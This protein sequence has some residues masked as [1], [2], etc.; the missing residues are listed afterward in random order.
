[1]FETDEELAE[2]WDTHTSADYVEDW[3]EIELEWVPDEDTCLRCGSRMNIETTD[4]DLFGKLAIRHLTRYS[5]PVCHAVRL[6][7]RSLEEI[8]SLDWQIR[9]YGLAGVVLQ[10]LVSVEPASSENR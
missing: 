4:I 8:R 5:C 3:E 2:F 1:M 6:S 9:R 10:N 7:T